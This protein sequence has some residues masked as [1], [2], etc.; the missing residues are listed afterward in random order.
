MLNE[1]IAKMTKEKVI[2]SVLCVT[3]AENCPERLFNNTHHI[4]ENWFMVTQFLVWDF[5]KTSKCH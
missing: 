5:M 2:F 1:I 3:R 4:S